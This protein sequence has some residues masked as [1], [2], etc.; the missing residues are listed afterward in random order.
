MTQ[1]TTDNA[2]ARQSHEALVVQQFGSQASAYV[3][4]TVHAQGADLQQMVEIAARTPNARAIDLGCGGGHVAYGVA[5]V[6][7]SVVAYDLSSGMLEAVAAEATKRG[8][9]NLTTRQGAAEQLPFADGEFDLVLSR[10]SAHHWQNVRQGIREARR[11]V[12]TGGT[13][14]IS[15]IIAPEVPVSDTFLQTFEM[16]RDPSHVRDYSSAEWVAI[17]SEAGF[18][19]TGVTRRRLPLDF[20]AW[21]GRMRTPEV[22]VAA[23]RALQ[24]AM[25]EQVRQHFAIEPDGSFTIDQAVFELVAI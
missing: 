4:S 25:S 2:A 20:D 9:A 15:D 13:V 7:A 11:V 24:A 22:Q 14:V 17:A 23:I 16:L 10:Y 8:F 12:K 6:L 18:A 5:P 1:S 3:A 19:V 21:V